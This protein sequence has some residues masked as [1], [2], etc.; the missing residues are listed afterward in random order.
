MLPGTAPRYSPGVVEKAASADLRMLN[1]LELLPPG[2]GAIA[3][4]YRLLAREID[5]SEREHD[6]Y[7][8]INAAA[9]LAQLRDRLGPATPF[10]PDDDLIDN[11]HAKLSAE[12]RHTTA[13]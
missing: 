9:R 5:R 3:Q 8:K 6:R 4:A 7:G 11:L 12:I 1:A 2:S 13:T 10:A